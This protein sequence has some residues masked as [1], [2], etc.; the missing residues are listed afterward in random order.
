MLLAYLCLGPCG[1]CL[2]VDAWVTAF[3]QKEHKKSP[4]A[5]APPLDPPDRPSSAATVSTR[6]I[7]VHLAVVYLMM[8]VGQLQGVVWVGG[9]AIAWLAARPGSRLFNLDWLLEHR[10]LYEGLTHAVLV[11]EL[12]FPVLIW[13]ALARP[14]LLGLSVILWGLLIPITG[15][16]TF[17]VV[18]IVAGLAYVPPET[19]RSL[20]PCCGP[21]RG[22]E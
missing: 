20:L 21:R 17:C 2:S 13:N 18:M 22:T 5:W 6:L 10:Y 19:M 15:M 9:D 8:A 4:T 12:A 11:F 1:A 7:Q 16:T 14:L 3:N